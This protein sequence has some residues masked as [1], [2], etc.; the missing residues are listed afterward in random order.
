MSPDAMIGGTEAGAGNIVAN[1][2]LDS[3]GGEGFGIEFD[4]S[5]G[6]IVLGNSVSKNAG[7]GLDSGVAFAP[8]L[9]SVSGSMITGRLDHDPNTTDNAP[10]GPIRPIGSSSSAL[11]IPAEPRTISRDKSTSVRST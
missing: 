7:R 9:T 4:P 8:M 11:P 5:S 10:R 6:V 2:A 1:T 3:G